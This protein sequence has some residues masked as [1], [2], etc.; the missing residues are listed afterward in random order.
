MK[1]VHFA[2]PSKRA[3]YVSEDPKA[4][5][6]LEGSLLFPSVFVVPTGCLQLLGWGCRSQDLCTQ[7]IL[8]GPV[9]QT[10]LTEEPAK[11]S[12]Y[13]ALNPP[14]RTTWGKERYHRNLLL[15]LEMDTQ[16]LCFHIHTQTL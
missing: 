6:Q 1:W 14:V 15:H 3:R 5:E 12:R 2:V 10:L 16:L 13:D 9:Q 8:Q 7:A 4:G 11:G